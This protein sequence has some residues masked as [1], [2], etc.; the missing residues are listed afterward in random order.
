MDPTSPPPTDR[1]PWPQR[2]IAAAV[3]LY[4]ASGVLCGGLAVAAIARHNN[5]TAF[6]WMTLAVLID[7][8]DGVLARRFS[9]RE[10]LPNVDGRKLDDIVD[11]LNYTFVPV[12]MLCES[13]W[14]PP[15]ARIWAAFPLVASLFAF[16]HSRAKQDDEGFFLGFPSYW[17]IVAFYVAVWLHRHGQYMVLGVVLGLSVLNVAPV[18]FVYPN[19]APCWRTFFVVGGIVWLLILLIMLYVYPQVPTWLVGLSAVYPGL[20]VALSL[21]L[22]LK[23]KRHAG[24][25]PRLP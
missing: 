9:I 6:L 5:R 21:Y 3:H 7:A 4:T 18:R 19:R 20:Y 2:V 1:A 25:S 13:G 11:Y 14:L 16:V 17:N 10:V 15:P 23:L 12:L 24:R 22:D 8:T